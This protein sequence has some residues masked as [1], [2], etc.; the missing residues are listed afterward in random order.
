VRLRT[1]W[2]GDPDRLQEEKD[3][4]VH[5]MVLLQTKRVF[6]AAGT[7]SRAVHVYSA[8]FVHTNEVYA[9][10]TGLYGL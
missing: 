1:Y 2:K 4:R 6:R 9:P 5:S 8:K 3:H 10:V 7:G